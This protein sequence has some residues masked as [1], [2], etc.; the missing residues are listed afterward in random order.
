MINQSFRYDQN[1]SRLEVVGVPD[2]S[3]GHKDGTLGILSSWKLQIVGFPQLEGKKEHLQNLIGVIYPYTQ[4]YLSGRISSFGNESSSVSIQP[5][6]GRHKLILRSSQK[7]TPPLS[8]VLD[9]A[10]VAD[11]IYSL[12]MMLND[13]NFS[14]G[15]EIPAFKPYRRNYSAKTYAN[16]KSYLSLF[17]GGSVFVIFT[18]LMLF[19]PSSI[20]EDKGINSIDTFNQLI[21]ND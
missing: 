6:N 19:M 13:P 9:D 12:D 11:L 8:I 4:F 21:K 5:F 10:E 18:A 2:I 20:K 7:D 14:V 3:Q 17:L 1:S 15:L 16:I